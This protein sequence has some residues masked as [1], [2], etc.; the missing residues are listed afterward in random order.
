MLSPSS[1]FQVLAGFNRQNAAA[2]P[3]SYSSWWLGGGYSQDLPFGFSAAF[4]TQLLF[5]RLRCAAGGASG[6][7]R[8]D[9]TL[10]LS[11]S[12][13]NRRFEYQGFTPKFSYSFTDQQS[14]IALYRYGR[15]QFQ[16]GLTSQF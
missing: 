11:F 2:S 7:T 4:P 9:R 13:L 5:H 6:V 14:N 15:S 10:S 1:L 12:L 16:I 8:A 3:Y